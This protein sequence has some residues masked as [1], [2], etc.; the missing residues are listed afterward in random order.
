MTVQRDNGSQV[1]R[2]HGDDEANPQ[3]VEPGYAVESSSHNS[4]LGTYSRTHVRTYARGDA[5]RRKKTL[6]SSEEAE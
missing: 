5:E 4:A 1:G 6:D 3:W 2:C